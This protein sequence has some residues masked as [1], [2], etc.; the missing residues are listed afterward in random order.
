[1]DS[2]FL[3]Q[4]PSRFASLVV[5]VR[6]EIQFLAGSIPAVLATGFSQTIVRPRQALV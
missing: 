5:V 6:L 2:L 4:L 1:M 3:A